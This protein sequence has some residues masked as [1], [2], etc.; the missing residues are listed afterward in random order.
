[1]SDD[2]KGPL[3]DL[4]ETM[5]DATEA[6]SKMAKSL[7]DQRAEIISLQFAVLAIAEQLSAN[8]NLDVPQVVQRLTDLAKS[9]E[10]EKMKEIVRP[11]ASL[12][13]ARLD[14]IRSQANPRPPRGSGP[15]LVK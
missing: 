10:S 11:K 4:A 9:V 12:F 1:M 14:Q 15:K 6:Q 13:A 8:G 7:I 5:I 2:L 3:I